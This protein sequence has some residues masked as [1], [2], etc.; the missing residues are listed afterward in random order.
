MGVPTVPLIVPDGVHEYE[1]AG[2]GLTF[3]V[4][5]AGSFPENPP[6][7][8]AKLSMCAPDAPGVQVN[9]WVAVSDIE[10]V[11]PMSPPK[12]PSFGDMLGATTN[13]GDGP[14]PAW[15]VNVMGNPTVPDAVGEGGHVYFIP[16]AVNDR[17]PLVNPGL[18]A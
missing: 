16:P 12:L 10:R 2:A 11:P 8:W 1:V 3:T 9:A 6:P 13:V 14:L 18:E 17:V 5:L 7:V 4:T 15:S